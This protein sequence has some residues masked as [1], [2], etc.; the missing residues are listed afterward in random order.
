MQ[1]CMGTIAIVTRRWCSDED[2]CLNVCNL[3]CCIRNGTEFNANSCN[4]FHIG[5]ASVMI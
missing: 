2:D 1:Q 5:P 3:Q 4:R